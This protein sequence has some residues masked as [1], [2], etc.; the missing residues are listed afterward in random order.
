[1]REYIVTLRNHCQT[2]QRR[3]WWH[4]SRG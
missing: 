4:I 2:R 1:V 3:D